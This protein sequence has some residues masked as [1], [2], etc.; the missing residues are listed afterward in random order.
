VSFGAPDAECKEP[1]YLQLNPNAKVPTI[2]DDGFTICESP[3]I[4]LHLAEKYKSPMHP[5]TLRAKASPF[6]GRRGGAWGAGHGMSVNAPLLRC[7][8]CGFR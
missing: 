6:L 1:W 5:S 2:D 3:A 4:N 7:G 8:T